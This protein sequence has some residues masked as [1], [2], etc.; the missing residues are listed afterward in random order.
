[1][2]EIYVKEPRN[3]KL[4]EV[5]FNI[6]MGNRDATPVRVTSKP[7]TFE[8]R[9]T[10]SFTCEITIKPKNREYDTLVAVYRIDVT[11]G[12][13]SKTIALKKKK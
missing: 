3:F 2:W 11:P 10:F 7:F 6:N 13:H 9:G 12:T 1:M 4:E 8:S 5:G